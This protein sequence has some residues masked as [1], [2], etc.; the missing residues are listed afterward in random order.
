MGW[1]TIFQCQVCGSSHKLLP[2][3][4]PEEVYKEINTTIITFSAWLW[5]TGA[6]LRG[7]SVRSSPQKI[8]LAS[9]SPQRKK[10]GKRGEKI[11]KVGRIFQ[12]SRF[13]MLFLVF[14][15]FGLKIVITFPFL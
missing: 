6:Y 15:I 5:Y 7:G 2:F 8:I 11:D 14:F 10:R 9:P 3:Y 1:G 4:L 12:I 13:F